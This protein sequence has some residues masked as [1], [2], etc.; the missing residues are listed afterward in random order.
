MGTGQWVVSTLQGDKPLTYPPCATVKSV[1][2][3]TVFYW[4]SITVFSETLIDKRK[5]EHTYGRTSRRMNEQS[6]NGH[7]GGERHEDASENS[8][9]AR[10]S[11]TRL[12]T[13]RCFSLSIGGSQ[14]S[15]RFRFHNFHFF[16]ASL[17]ASYRVRVYRRVP[18]PRKILKHI[19]VLC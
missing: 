9:G 3:F 8:V 18:S 1:V 16:P 17:S 13:H 4:A 7:T 14:L 11:R 5:D 19:L 6:G 15:L 10:D 2:R 12:E